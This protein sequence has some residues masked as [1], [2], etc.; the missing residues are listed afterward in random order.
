MVERYPQ[1]EYNKNGRKTTRFGLQARMI[2]S[3][4]SEV[5]T[6]S[7]RLGPFLRARINDVFVDWDAHLPKSIIVFALQP[8]TYKVLMNQR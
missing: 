3:G 5:S 4:V 6:N 1:Y 2:P 7:N 8:I